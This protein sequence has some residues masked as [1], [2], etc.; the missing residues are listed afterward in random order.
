MQ[1]GVRDLVSVHCKHMSNKQYFRI[2]HLS[3][4][5]GEGAIGRAELFDVRMT[6]CGR[7]P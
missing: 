5:G 7:L 3:R 4:R 2:A 1:S 6:D